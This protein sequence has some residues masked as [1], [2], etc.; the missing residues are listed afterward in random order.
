MESLEDYRN[1]KYWNKYFDYVLPKTGGGVLFYTSSNEAT[2]NW[3]ANNTDTTRNT[4]DSNTGEGVLWLLPTTTKIGGG[5]NTDYTP[6]YQDTGLTSVDLT[7][8]GLTNI[9]TGSFR[10]CSSLTSIHIPANVSVISNTAFYQD[11]GI[12]SISVASGN[13]TFNDGGGSNCI[14]K[15]SDNT[16]LF[17]CKNTVIPNTVVT[18]GTYAF[19][20]C[21][22]LTTMTIPN[23]VT[24]I[25]NNA[26][27]S[28]SGLTSFTI[29]SGVTSI[30]N[31]T[32]GTCN[33]LTSVTCLATTPPTLGTGN[34]PNTNDTLYVPAASVSAYENDSAWRAAFTNIQPIGNYS[35]ITVVA[36]SN[37]SVTGSGWYENG[38]TVTIGATA[39][40]HYH[41]TQWNDGDT[42]ATRT[43]T[44]TTNA[45][46]TAS[47]AID[48]FTI[49]ASPNSSSYGSVSGGGTYA[50]GATVTLTATPS[51]G[52]K[53]LQWNDE[54]TSNP[55]TITVTGDATYTALFEEIVHVIELTTTNESFL[56]NNSWV[57]ANTYTNKNTITN[58]GSGIYSCKIYPKS[59]VTKLGRDGDPY[60]TFITYSVLSVDMRESGITFCDTQSI[61]GDNVTSIIFPKEL[62]TIGNFVIEP[63]AYSLT[64]IDLPSTL[65][66]IG[67]YGFDAAPLTTVICRAT[68]PP[69]LGMNSFPASGDT[70]YVPAASV[71]AYQND[72]S[73]SAAFTTITAIP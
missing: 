69:T 11:Y 31:S 48:T 56:S 57:R 45:T 34:F 35:Y 47:F 10:Q 68:T 66:S 26:F 62:T 51:T 70:L 49:T 14:I 19:S 72:S 41:F 44:V 40:T 36:G 23:N 9:N 27:Q 20:K 3:V 18:I 55:R 52:Y 28:C 21:T 2:G 33:Y 30:G 7:Y 42:N 63:S 17:G 53:L 6:F 13:T 15:T 64:T 4:W 22:G 54:D 8:S 32:F 71:S 16:L 43:V 65:T 61:S 59:N 73:W 1:N 50:Y 38:T 37:G 39:D 46:Y 67:I 25:N 24:T 5:N 29:G 12:A 58:M 60:V